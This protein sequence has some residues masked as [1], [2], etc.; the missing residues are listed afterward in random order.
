MFG[1]PP[2]PLT[3]ASPNW[4]YRARMLSSE[5]TAYASLIVWNFSFASSL[6]FTSGWYCRACLRYAF[7]IS[8]SEADRW[9]PRRA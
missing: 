8:L 9:T 6:G 7:L 5:S 3:P 4:S 1:A 2:A